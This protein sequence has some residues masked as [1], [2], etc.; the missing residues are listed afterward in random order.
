LHVRCH[1]VVTLGLALMVALGVFGLQARRRPMYEAEVGLLITEGTFAA[2]GRPRPRGELRA[3]LTREIFTPEHLDSLIDKHRLVQMLRTGGRDG[4]RARLRKLIE[5]DTS[6]DY[7]EGYRDQADPPRSARVHISFSAPDPE[8]ALEV[9]EDIGKIV[10]KTQTQHVTEIANARVDAMRILAEKAA[11]RALDL[12]EQLLRAR[13][14]VG[15]Q[16]DIRSRD[17]LE[18]LAAIVESAQAAAR[19]SEANLVDAQLRVHAIRELDDLVQV[20][21]SS[22]P[23]WQRMTRA[24]RM[25]R[26]AILAMVVGI[27]A[28]VV[29]VGAFDPTVVDEQDIRRS[30]MVLVG[31]VP[32]LRGQLPHADV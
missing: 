1:P 9:A 19:Q 31:R 20:V 28:A 17:L 3:F 24:E 26:Q 15:D 18:Q 5:V 30:G 21:S 16:R 27:L 12:E 23:L 11:G 13:Q 32:I 6:H 25:L 8:L 4:A 29:L 10:A 2:D 7:F 22:A 14:D